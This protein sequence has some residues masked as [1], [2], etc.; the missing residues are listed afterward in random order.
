MAPAPAFAGAW[1]APE[2]GQQIWTGVAGTRGDISFF[3][4]AAYLEQPFA[5]RTSLVIAPSYEETNDAQQGWRAEAVVGVKHVL[6]RDDD[7]VLAAQAGALWRSDVTPECS[8]GGIE[9]RALGGRS[10]ENGAFLN[11]EAASRATVGRGCGAERVDVTAG[12]HFAGNWLALGQVFLD[13]PH[14]GEETLKAQL[15]LVRLFDGGGGIQLGLR[16]RVDGGPEEAAIVLGFWTSGD[17]D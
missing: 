3:E 11:V 10:F 12:S 1:L 7:I 14:Q 15:S 17:D 6:F 8:Q 9:L 4:G 5:Q 2:G 16:A 13:A